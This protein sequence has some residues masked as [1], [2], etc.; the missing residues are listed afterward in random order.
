M[1]SPHLLGDGQRSAWNFLLPVEKLQVLCL[2]GPGGSGRVLARCDLVHE[3]CRE[4]LD[5]GRG[6]WST[7]GLTS[8]CLSLSVLLLVSQDHTQDTPN[9][10][11]TQ[12]QDKAG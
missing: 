2:L 8:G 7:M 9:Q 11:M 12:A 1:K 5:T 3:F 6:V 10:R 4:A